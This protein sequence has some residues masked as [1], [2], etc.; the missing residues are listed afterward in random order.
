[1]EIILENL[2]RTFGKQIVFSHLNHHFKEGKSCAILGGNGSG[3]S[4]LLKII[5]GALSPT[6]GVVFYKKKDEIVAKEKLPFQITLAGPYLEL[7]EELSAN[8]F[9]T[10]FGKFRKFRKGISTHEILEK[11]LLENAADK[12][13]QN[14]SS[15]MKQRLRLGLALFAEAEV[16]LLDEPTSNLDPAGVKWY[17]TLIEE[18]IENRTLIIGSNFDENEMGFCEGKLEVGGM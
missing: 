6:S 4:T 3:K 8:E 11:C 17:Q 18:E 14:F 13:I 9:L 15:G 10:F 16:V 5:L 2:G 1:M 12:L 7:I